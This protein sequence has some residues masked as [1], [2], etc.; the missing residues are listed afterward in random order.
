MQEGSQ[1]NPLETSRSKRLHEE[2]IQKSPG[3]LPTHD[4]ALEAEIKRLNHEFDTLVSEKNAEVS[5][6]M[7]EKKFVWNQYELLETNLNNKLKSKE[8]EVQL[9]NEKL[10][11]LLACMEKLQSSNHDKDKAINELKS[12]IADKEAIA[13]KRGDEIVRLAQELELLRRTGC[14]LERPRLNRCTTSGSTASSQNRKR[15]SANVNKKLAAAQVPDSTNSEKVISFP[16]K[17]PS[18]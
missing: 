17:H 4:H 15:A 13:R 5:A 7:A 3:D 2:S 14:T 16:E 9:A 10:S 8:T 12:K 1:E 11:G 6:L 18:P